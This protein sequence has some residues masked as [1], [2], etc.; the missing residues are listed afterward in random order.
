MHTPEIASAFQPLP[1]GKGFLL[2]TCAKKGG[3]KYKKRASQPVGISDKFTGSVSGNWLYTI[4]VI[5]SILKSGFILMIDCI[6]HFGQNTGRFFAD[7]SFLILMRVLLLH[8]GQY[9][10]CSFMFCLLFSYSIYKIYHIFFYSL[11]P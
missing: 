7:V 10:H 1:H 3:V 8:T 6:L 2:R 4:C 5:T 11:Y 9:T